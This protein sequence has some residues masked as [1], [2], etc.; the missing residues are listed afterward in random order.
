MDV[1]YLYVNNVGEEEGPLPLELVQALM[2]AG[3]S[4]SHGTEEHVTRHTSHVTHH[5]SHITHH[6]SHVT[7]HTSHVARLCICAYSV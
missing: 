5:T 6:T 7:R 4:T 3:V 2:D 1:Q